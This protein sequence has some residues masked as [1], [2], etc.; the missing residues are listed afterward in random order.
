MHALAV[1]TQLVLVLAAC[2]CIGISIKVLKLM[3]TRWL[4]IGL[5]MILW[6]SILLANNRILSYMFGLKIP[7][8]MLLALLNVVGIG[9][10]IV[11]LAVFGLINGHSHPPES[12]P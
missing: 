10:I 7:S 1:F 4:K 8:V 12:K 5:L 2:G 6:G 11:S 3:P 9:C